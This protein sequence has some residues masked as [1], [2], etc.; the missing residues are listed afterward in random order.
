MTRWP[1]RPLLLSLAALAGCLS[2]SYFAADID[3][4]FPGWRPDDMTGWTVVASGDVNGDGIDD[5]ITA[6]P[7]VGGD[8]LAIYLGPL[9]SGSLPASPD[10]TF[11]GPPGAESGWAATV[12]DVTG[13]GF[14]DVVIGAPSTPGGGTVYV[15]EGPLLGTSYTP[16]N[17][18]VVMSGGSRFAGV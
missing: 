6:A 16:A 9:P 7:D 5:M 10:I 8:R 4:T 2:G 15:L 17:A 14:N 3:I 11:T 13:N 12:G 1:S 18:S